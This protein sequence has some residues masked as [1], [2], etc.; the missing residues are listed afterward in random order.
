MAAY[1]AQAY[2]G[3]VD[4][5][6]QY[7]EG[8]K[9]ERITIPNEQII[10]MMIE[11]NYTDRVLPVVY[12]SIAVN[13]EIYNKIIDLKDSA[14]FYLNVSA[15]DVI[16]F[17]SVGMES[18]RGLFKYIPETTNVD[19]GATLNKSDNPTLDTSY[20]AINIGLVSEDQTETLRRSFNAIYKNIDSNTLVG[21]AL[22]GLKNVVVEP[23]ENNIKYDQ[24]II[25]P[26]SSIYKFLEY[27]YDKDAFYNTQFRF[28]M[29]FNKTYLL[30]HRGTAFTTG[31][32]TVIL[33][34]KDVTSNASLI[35]GITKKNSSYYVYLS[36]MDVKYATNDQ[37]AS[38]IVNNVV[39]YDDTVETTSLDLNNNGDGR[40]R[41]VRTEY[42]N[43]VKN[44]I[45]SSN[46]IIEVVNDNMD[47]S[48]FTPEKRYCFVADGYNSKYNGIYTLYYKK[49][50]YKSV[51][52]TYNIVCSLAFKSVS[53]N[54]TPN[55]DSK[56]YSN[57][58][59][60]YSADKA[61]TADA[62][63]TSATTSL[64]R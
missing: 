22:Q 7:G 4:L 40:T 11:E 28:F 61:S 47:G 64:R 18:F 20:R 46:V 45:D 56:K 33:N 55:K 19:F 63:S 54:L 25:P 34:V 31:I 39:A 27:V 59:V 42:G 35:A 21:I 58:A 24:I 10:Y 37:A 30:S 14:H 1:T 50:F 15:T 17:N 5:Q 32:N 6:F 48:I 29:G 57:K 23:L 52:G 62:I 16:S 8:K 36:A 3:N 53:T 9:K 12:I 49:T 44:E 60:S 26:V 2:K 43:V 51:D 38:Q 41:F 13:N